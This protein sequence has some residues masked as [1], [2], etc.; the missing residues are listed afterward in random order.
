MLIYNDKLILESLDE[1]ATINPSLFQRIDD[2]EV[3]LRDCGQFGLHVDFCTSAGHCLAGFPWWDHADAD[4]RTMSLKDFPLG[5]HNRPF[6][7]SEQGWQILIWEC[8]ADVFVMEGQ[9]E[10][11]LVFT[12]WFRTPKDQYLQTWNTTVGDVNVRGGAFNSLTA[13]LKSPLAVRALLLG[14]RKLTALPADID[15]LP[16]LEFLG[17]YLNSLSALPRTISTL[18]QLKWLDLRFNQIRDLPKEFGA[19]ESLESVN[20]AENRLQEIPAC[21]YTL[22]KLRV[23]FVPGNP[24]DRKSIAKFR[25]ARPEVEVDYAQEI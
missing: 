2:F 24:I 9:D 17:L 10:D 14:N 15:R 19:L 20:I 25:R 13:A 7:D 6:Q 5:P 4:I 21:V 22:P 1:L 11:A 23:F 18:K 3:R 16:N 12:S 8:E